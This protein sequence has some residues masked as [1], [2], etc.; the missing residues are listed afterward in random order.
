MGKQNDVQLSSQTGH[1]WSLPKTVC[2]LR[3]SSL[4]CWRTRSSFPETHGQ[5]GGLAFTSP[6]ARRPGWREL[7]MRTALSMSQSAK[8]IRGDFPPSSRDT[9]FTLLTAQLRNQGEKCSMK[10]GKARRATL[11]Q[12]GSFQA[13]SHL[14]MM[15]FPISVEPVK[16]SLRT[17]GW[18]DRRCPTRA[19]GGRIW[20]DKNVKI[21]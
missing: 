12:P 15:C 17:S 6:R 3:C 16:P 20:R 4:P 9:F 18:S 14:F 2:R 21:S 13:E 11:F 7:T 1:G 19:P 5:H 10:H 8:M